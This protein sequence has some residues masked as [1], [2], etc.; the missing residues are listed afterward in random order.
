MT[1]SQIAK[2]AVRTR[3]ARQAFKQA[4]GEVV[5]LTVD[6]LVNGLTT[7]DIAGIMNTSVGSIA[8]IK[9]NLTRGTYNAAMKNCN[10]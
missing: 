4:F 9:A 10:L 6:G 2:K 7:K 8:A 3:K 5:Y 1:Q